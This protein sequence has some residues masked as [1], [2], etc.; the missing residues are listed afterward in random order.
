MKNKLFD[1]DLGLRPGTPNTGDAGN[2]C[3]GSD[4]EGL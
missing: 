3:L 2:L 4:F 1:I